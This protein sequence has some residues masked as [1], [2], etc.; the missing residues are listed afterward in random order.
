MKIEI[1][2][3][4]KIRSYE[5]IKE[6]YSEYVSETIPNQVYTPL[7]SD[8]KEKFIQENLKNRLLE[9]EA[10]AGD[11]AVN[12]HIHLCIP[13]EFLCDNVIEVLTKIKKRI[14]GQLE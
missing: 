5:W 6:N 10:L 9:V 11:H 4:Y 3:K 13:I 14:E 12:D 2:K 7:H 1:G 8:A